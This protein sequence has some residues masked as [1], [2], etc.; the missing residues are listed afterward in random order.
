LNFW[1]QRVKILQVHNVEC[2]VDCV[3]IE[4][5]L[6]VVVN[7]NNNNNNKERVQLDKKH[8]YEHV[9]KSVETSR[10]GKVTHTVE[11]TITNLQDHPQ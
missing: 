1:L 2:Q 10:G 11:P 3:K 9:P 6:V 4:A 5:Q 7:N 8:W